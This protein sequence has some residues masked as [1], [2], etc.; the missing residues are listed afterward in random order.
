MSRRIR[1]DTAHEEFI[2][3]LTSGDNPIFK[4]KWQPLMLAASIGLK[5]GERRPLENFD[6]G[7]AMP[8]SYFGPGLNGFLYLMGV[9]G[10][11]GSDCL[12]STEEEREKLVTAFEEHANAGLWKLRERLDEKAEVLEELTTF[13][14]ESS[15]PAL[16]AA[17][18]GNLSQI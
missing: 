1:R 12:H 18:L 6:S 13:L 14:I 8:P 16:P 4:E 2:A 7:K 17:D 3:R 10:S 15:A 5:A 9:A 11:E